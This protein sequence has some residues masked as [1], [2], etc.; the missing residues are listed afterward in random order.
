MIEML[1]QLG[2][3]PDEARVYEYLLGKG[4]TTAGDIIRHTEIKRGTAYNI[5]SDLS[6]KGFIRE[7]AA[8]GVAKFACEHPSKIAELFERK[9]K[10]LE[11]AE[12]SAEALL[13]ALTSRWNLSYHRPAVRYFEGVEGIQKIL[14]DS[15][16]AS[17]TIRSYIDIETIIAHEEFA[18]T[19][20]R[21]SAKRLKLGKSKKI[22][23]N[24]SPQTRAWGQ[25]HSSPLTERRFVHDLAKFHT[26]MQI[27]DNKVSYITVGNNQ[28]IGVI[29]DDP[30]IYEMHRA[31]FDALWETDT[32]I[33]QE[34][35][36]ATSSS[37]A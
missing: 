15:L 37:T 2:L 31:L 19:N 24:D 34:L 17:E 32:S 11:E 22:I 12:R 10:T 14:D 26:V 5:L 21:Y 18:K 25:K 3:S 1:N 6:A 28:T 23:E 27:Y 9:R 16:S 35:A 29:I 7:D 36:S 33:T 4:T 13:P 8:S 30:S 20:E